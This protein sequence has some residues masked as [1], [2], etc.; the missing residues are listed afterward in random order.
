LIIVPL[1]VSLMLLMA[2]G[3]TV[4]CLQRIYLGGPAFDSSHLIGMSFRLNMQ[5]YDESKTRQFQGSL[6]QRMATMPEITS[7]ALASAMP[8]S[9]GMGSFPLLTAGSAIS[10]GRSFPHADFN[11]VSAE[12][13]GTVGVSVVRGRGF[14]TSDREGSPPV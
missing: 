6:R 13:F 3:L 12:F 10:Q 11:V 7:V 8:L 4:R 9:N 1:A 5:G 14:T 2:A